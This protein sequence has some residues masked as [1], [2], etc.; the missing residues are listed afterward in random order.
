MSKVVH[1]STK[2]SIHEYSSSVH[3]ALDQNVQSPLVNVQP[4]CLGLWLFNQVYY[5]NNMGMLSPTPL[6]LSSL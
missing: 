3:G 2:V 1:Q 4:H 5:T 6:P